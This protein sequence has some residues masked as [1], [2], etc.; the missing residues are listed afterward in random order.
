MEKILGN[1]AVV[2]EKKKKKRIK[3]KSIIID[4]L[5]FL[6]VCFYSIF[7][8]LLLLLAHGCIYIIII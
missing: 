2:A 7:R 8:N 3:I 5:F 1:I 6:C 4:P